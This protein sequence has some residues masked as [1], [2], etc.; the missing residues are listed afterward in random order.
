MYP[1][2]RWAPGLAA[3][4]QFMYYHPELGPE[5]IKRLFG[6]MQPTFGRDRRQI[7]DWLAQGRYALCPRLP[8][9]GAGKIAGSAGG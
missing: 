6:D 3:A 2:I 1:R 7:T 8:R 5:F 4:L 9:H